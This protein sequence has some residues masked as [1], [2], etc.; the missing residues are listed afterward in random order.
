M[1]GELTL[2]GR[3]LAIGGL[4]EKSMAALRNGVDTV[5]IPKGNMPDLEEIDQTVRTQLNFVPV[6]TIEQVL[7]EALP[8]LKDTPKT[9]KTDT[10]KTFVAEPKASDA[11]MSLRI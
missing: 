1:T 10:P 5:I 8:V 11:N 2:H 7:D 4:R 3:V 6:E 9:P